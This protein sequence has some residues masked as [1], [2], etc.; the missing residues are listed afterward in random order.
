[1]LTRPTKDLA[2]KVTELEGLRAHERTLFG[3]RSK[4]P[5]LTFYGLWQTSKVLPERVAG[6]VLALIYR[7]HGIREGK[8]SG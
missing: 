5:Y 1:M 8:D 2:V 4:E 6:L 3:T 7:L